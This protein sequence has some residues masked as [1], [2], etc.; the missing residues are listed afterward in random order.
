MFKAELSKA[1]M[2][3][4]TDFLARCSAGRLEDIKLL[5][6]YGCPD[7]SDLRGVCITG[8][9][10]EP[11]LTILY[12]VSET[13][14]SSASLVLGVENGIRQFLRILNPLRIPQLPETLGL[15]IAI[16]NRTSLMVV[17]ILIVT[18]I[19]MGE[20][21]RSRI[22]VAGRSAQPP[23]CQDCES[24]LLSS[25]LFPTGKIIVTYNSRE[26]LSWKVY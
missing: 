10:L 6:W 25:T 4:P 2:P 26:P 5:A 18:S 15:T 16:F 13:C 3:T 22:A 20:Y 23:Q 21:Q 12:L 9:L 11:T 7:M 19:P 24:L 14:Q 8:Y 17:F 1:A